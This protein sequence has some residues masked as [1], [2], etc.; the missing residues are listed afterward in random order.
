MIL[1]GNA[2]GGGRDLAR[3]LMKT[4]NERVEV[5][6]L[7]GF[8]A[9]DLD[10]AFRET[11]AI[12]RGTRCQQYLFSRSLNPPKGAEVSNEEFER[13][14]D[15]AEAKLGL[16]G[17][18]RAIVFH[19]KE[20]RRHAHAVW[21]R[22]DT[23]EMKAINLPFYKTKL[24]EV[25][26]EIYLENGW[27]KPRG[28]VG[29][30]AR[31]P[32]NFT[33]AEWQQA[34]RACWHGRDL[35]GLMQECWAASDSKAA[36]EHALRERGITL[37]KGDRRGHVAI[38]HDGEVLSVARYTDKKAK[39]VRDKLGE[40]DQLPSVD[41]AK[42]QIAR[43]MSSAA[44]RY[45]QEARELHRREMEPLEARRQTITQ[46]HTDER[47]QH[48][49]AQQARWLEETRERSDRLRGGVRGLWDRLTGE[50]ARIVQQ[51]ENEALRAFQRDRDQRQALI[52][53]QLGERQQLQSKIEVARQ[54][55]A[56][57]LTELRSERERYR[58]ISPEPHP[59]PPVRQKFQEAS[60]KPP[61][62]TAPPIQ[63]HFERIAKLRETALPSQGSE[64]TQRNDAQQDMSDRLDQLR[65]NT[66]PQQSSPGQER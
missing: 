11:Y 7:R 37:A 25:S 16:S 5:A 31:D 45:I 52:D 29:S 9:D 40:L 23:D 55:Q 51:N 47:R 49:A 56:E 33:L 41:D 63:D 13:A 61:E 12:S 2:R 20:G 17:Q 32:R 30:E 21:S 53:A 15:R 64:A 42:A 46:Q 34:K 19:E 4:E 28:F 65:R 24:R 57:L 66:Q 27:Q 3:H 10:G 50:H 36:F 35:K 59:I 26:K 1:V 38:T 48:D 43:D 62:P 58:Q 44:M 60:E 8:V 54:R 14:I 18:P 39:E 22:I 6:E